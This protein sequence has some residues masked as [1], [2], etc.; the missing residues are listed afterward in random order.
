MRKDKGLF[1]KS[2]QVFME[3]GAYPKVPKA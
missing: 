2:E 3:P 1:V